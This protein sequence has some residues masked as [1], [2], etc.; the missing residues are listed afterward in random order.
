MQDLFKLNQD[1]KGWPKGA[2]VLYERKEDDPELE[3]Y[4]QSLYADIGFELKN[5]AEFGH[6]IYSIPLELLGEPSELEKSE[7][8]RY[9]SDPYK[10]KDCLINVI[11]SN[12]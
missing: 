11:T 3:E 1:F 7:V 8:K 5:G 9:L 10:Y 4:G 2:L 6:L 12:N